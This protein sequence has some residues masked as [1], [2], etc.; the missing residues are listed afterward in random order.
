MYV[1]FVHIKHLVMY[2]STKW[3]W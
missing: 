1:N 2:W 3:R